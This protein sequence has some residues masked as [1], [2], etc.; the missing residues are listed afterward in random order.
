MERGAG[1]QEGPVSPRYPRFSHG[2]PPARRRRQHR[3]RPAMR[4]PIHLA[5]QEVQP[6]N[7]KPGVTAADAATVARPFAHLLS[8]AEAV[9]DL[10]RL[11]LAA[12]QLGGMTPAASSGALAGLRGAW[13]FLSARLPWAGVLGLQVAESAT[14]RHPRRR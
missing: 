6:V 5:L 2:A 1:V 3:E 10:V 4:H 11:S 9:H 14:V 12:Q 7:Y 13:D 8:E